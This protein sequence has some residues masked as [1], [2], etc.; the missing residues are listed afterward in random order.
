[1]RHQ[2]LISKE[3]SFEYMRN[4]GE[5][6]LLEALDELEVSLSTLDGKRSDCNHIFLNFVPCVT[7]DPQKVVDTVRDFVLRYG[8]RLWKLRVLQV[9]V[10]LFICMYFQP[11]F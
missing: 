6:V 3:A 9:S 2:D 4:E 5:R 7:L 8:A 1:M 11:N 10:V